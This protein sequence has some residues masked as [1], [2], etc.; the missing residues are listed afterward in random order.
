MP[1][2]A[3]AVMIRDEHQYQSHFQGRNKEYSSPEIYTSKQLNLT[4]KPLA[5]SRDNSSSRLPRA[6]NNNRG[7]RCV[8]QDRQNNQGSRA[9]SQERQNNRDSRGVSQ[10]RQNNKGSRSVLQERQNNRN[11]RAVSQERQSNRDPRGVS[12]ERTHNNRAPRGVSQERARATTR[13]VSIEREIIAPTFC[14]VRDDFIT[15]NRKETSRKNSDKTHKSPSEA[16]SVQPKSIGGAAQENVSEVSQPTEEVTKKPTP[17]A[18][19]I[20]LGTDKEEGTDQGNKKLDI[21]ASISKWAPKH[22]RNLSLSKVEENKVLENFFDEN[23]NSRRKRSSTISR[24]D[25]VEERGKPPV[26]RPRSGTLGSTSGSSVIQQPPTRRATGYHSEG[27]FSSDQD[28][29]PRRTDLKSPRS[30][31]TPEAK[32]PMAPQRATRSA[33]HDS[34]RGASLRMRS[35]SPDMGSRVSAANSDL[36]MSMSL[37]E[38]ASLLLG[39]MLATPEP[40]RK[41]SNISGKSEGSGRQCCLG[42]KKPTVAELIGSYKSSKKDSKAS[43]KMSPTARKQSDSLSS[44]H[45][46]DVNQEE[47]DV[48]EA[49]TYTIGNESP[50][51]E[52]ARS[53][54]DNVFGVPGT[55]T[56]ANVKAHNHT[57]DEP[58]ESSTAN[59]SRASPNWIQQWAAQVAEQTKVTSG[60]ATSPQGTKPPVTSPSPEGSAGRTRRKLPTVPT[61]QPASPQSSLTLTSPRASDFSDVESTSKHA[62]VDT[63]SSAACANGGLAGSPFASQE[64]GGDSDIDTLTSYPQTDNDTKLSQAIRNKLKLSNLESTSKPKQLVSMPSRA[65]ANLQGRL[66]LA[67][68]RERSTM[69]DVGYDRFAAARQ[70][71]HCMQSD[72]SSETSDNIK[73]SQKATEKNPPLKY[74]RAFSL[75]RAR[76]EEPPA[77]TPEKA[78]PTRA[79]SAASGSGRSKAPLTSSK[80]V[81]GDYSKHVSSKNQAA[82]PKGPVKDITRDDG[83]RFSLRGTRSE[84]TTSA[85][86]S[87][88]RKNL[89]K[90]LLRRAIPSRSNST[91]SSKEAEFQNWKRRKNYDPMKAAAEGRK[92]QVDKKVEQQNGGSRQERTPSP[93][94]LRSQSFHGTEGMVAGQKWPQKGNYYEDD[95][96]NSLTEDEAAAVPQSSPLRRCPTSPHSLSSPTQSTS[97]ARQAQINAANAARRRK[98]YTLSDDGEGNNT[99]GSRKASFDESESEGKSSPMGSTR[100]G[101]RTKVK[102]EALDNLVISTIHSL[103]V[104]VRT[105]SETLLQNLR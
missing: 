65:E 10:D 62:T 29:E 87:P 34:A 23:G 66:K 100:G 91:M 2:Y 38:S 77:T 68:R 6:Q 39:K 17:M 45:T 4:H 101:G 55:K 80:S 61:G 54:I 88:P 63:T 43:D 50:D 75:R 15:G 5:R 48:S 72:S 95:E 18:F 53:N 14:L 81:Q 24:L 35:P 85:S 70:E 82:S 76:L 93:Q 89:K 67:L 60:S 44:C 8:S 25:K 36:N 46:Y 26:G 37:T 22:R 84:S 71:E 31:R 27:Y 90:D 32:S 11:S 30:P 49:G 47:D 33:S 92:K 3:S 21:N 73:E 59:V 103:S 99:S 79:S 28:D 20:D 9:V 96:P 97:P 57:A 13:G 42:E 1:A 16:P 83:G 41:L 104:K 12:K 64:S 56:D 51:V 78:K 94:L 7:P 98:S 40:K 74:N 86:K 69:S 58:W 102:M 19:T 105:T 52:K